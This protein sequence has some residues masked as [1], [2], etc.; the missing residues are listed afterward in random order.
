MI[1]KDFSNIFLILKNKLNTRDCSA[2]DCDD[3]EMCKTGAFVVLFFVK[4]FNIFC[5]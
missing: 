3:V 5:E 2:A 1:D 4:L